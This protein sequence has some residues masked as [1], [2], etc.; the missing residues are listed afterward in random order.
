MKHS[1]RLAISIKS[2]FVMTLHLDN[3]TDV[4]WGVPIS[5]NV[6][7]WERNVLRL[8]EMFNDWNY[9]FSFWEYGWTARRRGDHERV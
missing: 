3:S 4:R 8:P 2:V 7:V 5:S 9:P 1:Y 6:Y